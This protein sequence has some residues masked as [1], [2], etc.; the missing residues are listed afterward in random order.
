MRDLTDVRD[1]VIGLVRIVE[2]DA[3]GTF[4]LG[5]GAPRSLTEM[6]AAVCDVLGEEC[7]FN[8]QPAGPEEVPATWA[9]IDRA[10]RE[11]DYEP[12]TDLTAIVRRQ[13]ESLLTL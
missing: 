5:A 12:A 10:R 2:R 13:V 9:S 7:R 6:A 11:L 4:N 1:V 8:V 3:G